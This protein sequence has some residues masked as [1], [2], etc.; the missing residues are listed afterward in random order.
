MGFE[1]R[2]S[3]VFRFHKTRNVEGDLGVVHT[4]QRHQMA[5]VRNHWELFGEGGSWI[6]IGK[7][8]LAAPREYLHERI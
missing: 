4:R 2:Y 1:M 8:H 6:T 7:P 3:Q 5:A